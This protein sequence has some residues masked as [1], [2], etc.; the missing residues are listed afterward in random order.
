M[1]DR[2]TI[3][4]YARKCRDLARSTA[5][6]RTAATLR[7]MAEEYEQQAGNLPPE[8]EQPMPA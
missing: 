4:G 5:D 6:P 7:G 8:P 3:L 1:T 2:R